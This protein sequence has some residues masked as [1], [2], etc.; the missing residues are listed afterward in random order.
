M[1]VG[2]IRENHIPA[3]VKHL[4]FLQIFDLDLAADSLGAL[5]PLQL[6]AFDAQ[7]FNG[8]FLDAQTG[9]FDVRLDDG[10]APAITLV[11]F[12]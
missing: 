2:R 6:D 9:V 5:A 10:G 4:S 1:R 3:L 12:E 7:G 8:V 11:V